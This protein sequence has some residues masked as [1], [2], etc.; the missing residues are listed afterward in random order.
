[1]NGEAAVALLGDFQP[2][3]W[4]SMLAIELTELYH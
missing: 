3:L 1:M 2:L 4:P